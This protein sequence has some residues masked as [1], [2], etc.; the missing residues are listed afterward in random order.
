MVSRRIERVAGVDRLE[1]FRRLL[2]EADQ[3]RTHHIGKQAGTGGAEAQHL[4]AMG[5]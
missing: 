1:E 4:Q 3:R 2:D 5:E